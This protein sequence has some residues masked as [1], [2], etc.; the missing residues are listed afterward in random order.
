VLSLMDRDLRQT[1][2][3]AAC[4]IGFEFEVQEFWYFPPPRSTPTSSLRCATSPCRQG[5][6]HQDIISGAGHTPSI[7]RASPHRD[8]LRALRRRH[9]PQRD[10]GRQAR[11]SDR[12][13]QRAVERGAGPRERQFAK[14]RPQGEP[15]L[16]AGPQ[17][18]YVQPF[19]WRRRDQLRRPDRR[20]ETLVRRLP[21][22]R[23]VIA[24]ISI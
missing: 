1:C 4:A 14:G 24:A 2:E 6:P 23:P 15:I 16:N 11:G 18:R 9:Q 19:S 12:R 8:G 7:W 21:A 13:P 3:G 22:V 20:R 10:R 17:F 5:Y